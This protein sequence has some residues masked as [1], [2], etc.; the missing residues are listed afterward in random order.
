MKRKT[1]ILCTSGFLTLAGGIVYGLISGNTGGVPALL[2]GLSAILFFGF[3]LS[4]K[5]ET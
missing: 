3:G 4:W 2:L 5:Q 1:V